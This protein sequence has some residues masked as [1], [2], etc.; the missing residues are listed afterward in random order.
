MRDVESSTRAGEKSR[1]VGRRW[2][3]EAGEVVFD[4]A[5][6]VVVGVGS[7]VGA[8]ADPGRDA[9]CVEVE[10]LLAVG[11]SALLAG[12]GKVEGDGGGVVGVSSSTR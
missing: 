4:K 11:V 7:G 3:F 9:V 5:V 12:G 6:G 1:A 8:R 2:T 10:L